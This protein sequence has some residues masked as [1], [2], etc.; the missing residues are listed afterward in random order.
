MK[1]ILNLVTVLMVT[2]LVGIFSV[3]AAS[4]TKKINKYSCG[5]VYT[6]YYLLLEAINEEDVKY[7]DLEDI[8]HVTKGIYNN[9]FYAT[10]FN[11]NNIGYGEVML[12]KYSGYDDPEGLSQISMRTFYD[13]YLAALNSE[14]IYVNYNTL[15]CRNGYC[16]NKYQTRNYFVVHDW[17]E[18][19]SYSNNYT[20]VDL[21]NKKRTQLLEASLEIS[22]EITMLSNVKNNRPNP[23]ELKIERQ[24]EGTLDDAIAVNVNGTR[25]YLQ[26][27]LYYVQYCGD[28]IVNEPDYNGP[29]Q[30][31]STTG[32]YTINYNGNGSNVQNVPSSVYVQNGSC[33]YISSQVPT[34][35]G[36]RFIGWNTNKNASYANYEPNERYCGND[37]SSV[38][39]YAIW[40][41]SNGTYK[42]D[43]NTNTHDAVYN[44]PEDT[45]TSTSYDSYIA[46]NVPTR[47]GYTFLGWSTNPYANEADYRYRPN[48]VYTERR[49]IVLYAVW[50]RNNNIY[51]PETGITDYLLPFG[52]VI[53]ASGTGLGILKKKKKNSFKQF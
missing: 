20:T 2:I 40:E 35:N 28:E 39:L 38:T 27:A 43:Y 42:I 4:A 21:K 32:S 44:F 8:H 52:G 7:V 41:S 48:T 22:T 18:I 16:S 51:N 17:E 14:D 24:Y 47:T 31:P 25:Y 45:I 26:P 3:N 13:I 19:P 9:N 36:Y 11:E 46:S 33:T 34:R 10:D 23:F 12:S 50:S 1:K 30:G 37:E 6:N 29:T 5:T 53:A 15:D 49:D